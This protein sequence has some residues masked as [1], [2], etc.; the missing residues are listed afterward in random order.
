MASNLGFAQ[1]AS[2]VLAYALVRQEGAIAINGQHVA[3]HSHYIRR[4]VHVLLSPYLLHVDERCAAAAQL[5]V[6]C[7]QSLKKLSRSPQSRRAA[8][9]A[10]GWVC[11]LRSVRLLSP[12]I[13]AAAAAR[14]PCVNCS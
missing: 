1:P 13:K 9:Q 3:D 4:E 8:G 5:C 2:I 11:T 6:D 14:S 7:N 12:S 10:G